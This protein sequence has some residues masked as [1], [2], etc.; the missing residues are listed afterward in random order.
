MLDAV[1]KTEDYLLE[2]ILLTKFLVSEELES[3]SLLH[4]L[5]L[6]LTWLLEL[7]YQV[8]QVHLFFVIEIHL[9]IRKMNSS[10]LVNLAVKFD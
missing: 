10:N 2:G 6:I 4:R 1:R 3:S 8:I 5:K 9:I 7:L